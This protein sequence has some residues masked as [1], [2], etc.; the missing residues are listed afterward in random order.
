MKTKKEAT[1]A[2]VKLLAMDL[3]KSTQGGSTKLDVFNG[4]TLGMI[5]PDP[6]KNKFKF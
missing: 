3:L 2:K 4:Q 1:D 5:G 6:I